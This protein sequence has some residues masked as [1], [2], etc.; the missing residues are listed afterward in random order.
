MSVDDR[1]DASAREVAVSI[2]PG[3][4]DGDDLDVQV[5]H[6]PVD[7]EGNL[8]ESASV[9]MERMEQDSTGILRFETRL[10]AGRPGSHGYHVR[11]VPRHGELGH[12]TAL[13]QVLWAK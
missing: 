4:L 12:F 13:H 3:R 10:R 11:V 2:D 5:L 9:S 8:M 1:V 7:L 6:G